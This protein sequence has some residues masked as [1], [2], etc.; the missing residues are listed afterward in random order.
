MTVD[1][2]HGQA[3]SECTLTLRGDVNIIVVVYVVIFIIIVVIY[4][5]VIEIIVVIYGIV[6]NI[7]INVGE[8]CSHCS[9]FTEQGVAKRRKRRR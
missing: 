1:N 2:S 7:N 3:A 5:V 8:H 6:I 9:L 4:V